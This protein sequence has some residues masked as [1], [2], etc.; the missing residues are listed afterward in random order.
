[1]VASSALPS[2]GDMSGIATA[3]DHRLEID[4]SSPDLGGMPV[5]GSAGTVREL[6][7]IVRL[8]SLREIILRG[9][10][11]GRMTAR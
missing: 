6:E 5:A 4:G 2:D 11:R 3:L 8:G 7:L 1:M 10:L 9:T